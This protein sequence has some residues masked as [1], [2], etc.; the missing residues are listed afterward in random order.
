MPGVIAGTA[1]VTSTVRQGHMVLTRSY[2][3]VFNPWVMRKATVH[4]I[5]PTNVVKHRCTAG[6]TQVGQ[7]YMVVSTVFTHTQALAANTKRCATCREGKTVCAGFH[8]CKSRRT[9]D[10][11]CLGSLP[12]HRSLPYGML[13]RWE[14]GEATALLAS[15]FAAET[16]RY[17]G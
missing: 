7:S 5:P 12:A 4:C 2:T 10:S 11:S 17:T 6:Y 13:I 8:V 15:C 3:M 16:V 14:R 1:G 9:P